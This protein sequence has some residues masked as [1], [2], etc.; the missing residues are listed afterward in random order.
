LNSNVLNGLKYLLFLLLGVFLLWLSFRQ[1]D[2]EEVW[3]D[4]LKANYIWLFIALLFTIISHIFRALRW[5]LLINSMGYQTKLTTTFYAVMVGYM[6]NTAVPRMGEFMRCG[7]LARKRKIPFNALIGSVISE[8]IFDMLIL[9]ILLFSVVIFQWD[10]AGGFVTRLIGPLI[11]SVMNNFNFLLIVTITSVLSVAAI[12]TL[13]LMFKERIKSLPGYGK[14]REIVLGLI[15]GAKTIKRVKQKG[16]FLLYTFMIWLFYALMIYF[17]F[18]MLPETD[19]LDFLAAITF[20]VIGSLGIVAPVP[21]GIGAYHFIG[22]AT[23][24]ELYGISGT[25]AGSFVAIT[26]AGQ[27]LLNVGVGAIGYFLLTFIKRK[28]QQDEQN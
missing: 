18:K 28:K 23:L 16:L 12:I 9:L 26:H 11:Q 17:P 6:A 5:N 22:K 13:G 3:A 25:I 4:I 1:L 21:G 2:L 27:T 7:M 19:H 8:R 10:L 24:V 20:L 14:T 15:A